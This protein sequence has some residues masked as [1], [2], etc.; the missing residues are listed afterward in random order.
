MKLRVELHL[1]CFIN[2]SLVRIRS[3]VDLATIR[4]SQ[5]VDHLVK[6][7]DEFLIN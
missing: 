6:R 2:Y 1:A 4:A 3:D 7:F 5:N